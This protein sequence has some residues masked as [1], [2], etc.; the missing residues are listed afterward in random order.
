MVQGVRLHSARRQPQGR[1]PSDHQPSYRLGVDGTLAR[2][3]LQ[4]H[5]LGTLLRPSPDSRE[6]RPQQVPRQAPRG[7]PP[8]LHPLY[9]HDRLGTVLLH[10]RESA[11][12]FPRRPLQLRQRSVQRDSAQPDAQLPAGS[13]RRRSGEHTS[14]RAPL[15]KGQPK[16]VRLDSRDSCT[17]DSKG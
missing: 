3:L 13:R 2:S 6:V 10:R 8:R 5:F 4:L 16:K 9:R 7:T 1:S 17:S 14:R 12:C 15:L 11:L